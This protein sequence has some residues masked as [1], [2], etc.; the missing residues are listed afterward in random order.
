MVRTTLDLDGQTDIP[1]PEADLLRLGDNSIVDDLHRH[2]ELTA[3]DGAPDPAL[4][5]DNDGKIILSAGTGINE[6][7]T[8]VSLGASDD[9]VPTQNAVKSYIDTGLAGKSDTSHNHTLDGLSNTTITDIASG[10]L[11]KWNGSAW[12]NNTLSEAGIASDSLATT[13]AAGIIELATIAETSPGSSTD[14]AITPDAL[15]GSRFGSK[16]VCLVPLESDQSAVVGDGKAAFTIGQAMTGMDLLRYVAS[17]H[18]IG[19]GTVTIQIRRRR[20]GTDAD[21]LSTAITLTNEYLCTD[22]AINTS[23]DDVQTGDQIY[24]DIDG[25]TATAPQGLSVT[26]EFGMP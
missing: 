10:E 18:T 3:P 22:G 26:L 7:S 6:F 4:Y 13:S 15:S 17:C 25:V 9:K 21:M 19:S 12:V 14:R 16:S 20:A 23:Y 11:L 24:I 8:D 5:I 1:I 2:S